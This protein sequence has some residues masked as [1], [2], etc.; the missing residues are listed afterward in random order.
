MV[1]LRS[2]RRLA[3]SSHQH[4]WG[5]CDPD[6]A[7]ANGCILA[8]GD[9]CSSHLSPGPEDADMEIRLGGLSPSASSAMVHLQWWSARKSPKYYD[10]FNTLVNCSVY[11]NYEDAY[12]AY[13]DADFNGGNVRVTETGEALIK[14]R[15]P[16]TYWVWRGIRLPHIHLRLCTGEYFALYSHDTINFGVQVAWVSSGSRANNIRIL[17]IQRYQHSVTSTPVNPSAPEPTDYIARIIWPPSHTSTT[18]SA[19]EVETSTTSATETTSAAATMAPTTATA[20]TTAT[21]TATKTATETATRTT[22]ETATSTA[23]TMATNT[24]A[25]ALELR[26]S[27]DG[28]IDAAKDALDLDALEFSPVYQCLMD[29]KLYDHFSSAC[30][31]SCGGGSDISQG[32]CVREVTDDPPIEIQVTWKLQIQCDSQPCWHDKKNK[33]LHDVRLSLAGHLDIPFQEVEVSWGFAEATG[34]RLS[35]MTTAYLQVTVASDRVSKEEGTQLLN[36]FIPDKDFAAQ[37]LG[38]DV[39]S[40]EEAGAPVDVEALDDPETMGQGRDPYEPAYEELAKGTGSSA[41]PPTSTLGFLPPGAIIGI[42]AGVLVLGI[43]AGLLLWRRSR[44]NGARALQEQNDNKVAG[45]KVAEPAEGEEKATQGSGAE[46]GPVEA[47]V[48]L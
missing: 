35:G 24:G 46:P 4:M 17:S 2:Q 38:L 19:A 23:P 10:L 43:G 16:A 33:T 27:L 41:P 13:S 25:T 31:E 40:V 11:K 28:V 36:S 14:I 47:P 44:R 26:S 39:R 37:L 9:T 3:S 6:G 42:A 15:A 22:T 45:A 34:R 8:G 20:T 32:Q 12:P 7:Q 48:Q 5:T 1:N 18:L 30:A 29:N 21:E